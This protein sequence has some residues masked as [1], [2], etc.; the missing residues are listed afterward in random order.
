M[1]YIKQEERVTFDKRVDELSEL[2]DFDGELNYVIT[3]LCHNWIKLRA[4]RY[5]WLN[6]VIGVLECAKLEFYRMVVG[7]YEDVKINR[8]GK[9]SEVD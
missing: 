4:K 3:R 6:Q 7:P 9:V 2:I 8:N 5:T 1:P